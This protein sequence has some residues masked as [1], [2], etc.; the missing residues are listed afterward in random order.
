MITIMFKNEIIPFGPKVSG[1]W[2]IK[3]EKEKEK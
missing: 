3:K 2:S 1:L